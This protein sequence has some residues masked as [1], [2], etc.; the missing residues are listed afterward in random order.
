MLAFRTTT[1]EVKSGYG[2]RTADEVKTRRAAEEAGRAAGVDVVRT[3]LG[4][5]AIPPEFEGRGDAYV[6]LVSD[7]MV[8]AVAT[9]RLAHK[10]EAPH[11]LSSRAKFR[12][13]D[14]HCPV[15]S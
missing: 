13:R 6:D 9:A 3:F 12:R 5:H 15:L 4:A 8:D 2:L 11:V 10:T 14:V 1:I 7:E